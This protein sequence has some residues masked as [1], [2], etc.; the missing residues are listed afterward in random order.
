MYMFITH[1]SGRGTKSLSG[2]KV[3]SNPGMVPE[4]V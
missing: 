4:K 1:I 2:K 3:E